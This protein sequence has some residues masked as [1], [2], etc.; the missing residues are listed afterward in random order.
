MFI[1]IGFV[2]VIGCVLVG[3]MMHGGPP[4]V[5]LQYNEFI[6]IGGAGIGSLLVGT[7]LAILK[8]MGSSIGRMFKGDQFSKEQYVNLLRT[9]FE[10]F[11]VA[12]RDGLINV[13]AHIEK[14]KE[15]SIFSKNTF[16]LEQHHALE[17]L[18][19]TMKLMLGG[20]IAAHD[21][22]AM[23]DADIDSH[24]SE[25]GNAPGIVQT[26]ADAF[27]GLGIVAAVLGIIVTMGAI[28][29]PPEEIG[30]KVAAA[31]VGTFIGILL[32]YG[33]VGP[34]A[35]HM[36]LLNASEARFYEC[37][38]AGVVAY[39]KG[40]APIVVVEFARRVIF[41]SVRPSFSEIETVI[42]EA[43]KG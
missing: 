28:N 22:E 12:Q 5:L 36:E 3:F 26:L 34:M 32:S 25:T 17:F 6:I 2:I 33:F 13:E 40:N 43:R 41:H 8:Q 4:A 18:C 35:K 15:S 21:L 27:P 31:L 38:K 11:N 10:L 7:P 16:L 1:I 37:I 30:L 19:D 24:H 42:K 20:G 39:A 23:L 9:M 14:P 29:G